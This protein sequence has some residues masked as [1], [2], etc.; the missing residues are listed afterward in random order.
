MCK[1]KK[2]LMA[3]GTF[4]GLHKGHREVLLS[5]KTEYAAK[6]AM[7]FSEHPQMVLNGEA[8]GELIT[9]AKRDELFAEWGYKPAFVSFDGISSLSPEEFIDEILVK[10]YGVTALCCGFNYRFGKGASGD[11]ALLRDLCSERGIKLTVCP[12]VDFENEPISSTRIRQCLREGDI[13]S[14]NAMLGRRFSY[15][16]EVVHGDKRGRT[17]GSPTINQFFSPNFTVPQYGVYASVTVV[18][19]KQYSSVTNIGIRPTIGSS[20]KRSET[21][22]IGYDGDLYGKNI[23]VAL[24]KKIRGE[25]QFSSLEELSRQIASDRERAL[26]IISKEV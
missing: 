3:L 9:Q 8:P 14:A 16:F 17:L 10:G 21:N 1:S 13:P 15:N 4:D 25:K 7:V 18:D 24:V 26:E 6:F 23:E 11:V 19:G 22:I 20:E 2:I 5:D 12:Q